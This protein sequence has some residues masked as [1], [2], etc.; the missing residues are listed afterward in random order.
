[1]NEAW[2][3]IAKQYI[4]CYNAIQTLAMYGIID[5]EEKTVHE[6]NLLHEI[7]GAFEGELEE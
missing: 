4:D 1:M 2:R 3:M 5:E 6:H 7:V